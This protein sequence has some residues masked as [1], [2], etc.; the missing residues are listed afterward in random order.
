MCVLQSRYKVSHILG[1]PMLLVDKRGF[2][3]WLDGNAGN[4]GFEVFCIFVSILD[5][6]LLC[7]TACMA[8]HLHVV[9]SKDI[10][11]NDG[12]C[13]FVSIL[14]HSLLCATACMAVHLHVV[15][16]KVVLYIV[17]RRMNESFFLRDLSG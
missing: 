17:Q 10:A 2:M 7:A 1:T 16:S 8:V 9:F 14:D 12:F 11:G 13:I 6:S 3:D 15:F 5:H 4:D